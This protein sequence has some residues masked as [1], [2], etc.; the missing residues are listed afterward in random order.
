MTEKKPKRTY[1]PYYEIFV[2][3]AIGL[4]AIVVVGMLIFTIAIGMGVL[5]FS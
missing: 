2:P 1:P 3:V 5:K 4:L